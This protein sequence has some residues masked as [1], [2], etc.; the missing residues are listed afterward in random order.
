MYKHRPRPSQRMVSSPKTCF[1]VCPDT[2]FTGF[3]LGLR[4]QRSTAVE[5]W[6]SRSSSRIRRPAVIHQHAFPSSH[7]LHP[8]SRPAPGRCSSA[9]LQPSTCPRY[10]AVAL[11]L[12]PDIP[13]AA[14]A[15]RSAAGWAPQLAGVRIPSASC[16]RTWLYS[17]RNSS[18]Q[19]GAACPASRA[20]AAPAPVR[21]ESAPPCPA[22][23]DADPAP[24]Q[25]DALLHQ[26]YGSAP[27]PP[28]PPSHSTTACHDPS[29]SPPAPRS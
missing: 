12:P 7:Q 15:D 24:V 19:A 8:F 14:D 16:G 26:P 5:R 23:A 10:P 11:A 25:L 18:S 20:A 9:A 6:M 1:T 29:A 17:Q 21:H 27:S 28:W 2:S 13:N 22:S 3:D 4:I